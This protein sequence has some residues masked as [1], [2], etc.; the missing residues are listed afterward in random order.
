VKFPLA[1]PSIEP[2]RGYEQPASGGAGL[3]AY[4]L[5]TSSILLKDEH[6]AV[7][8]DG[9]VTRPSLLRVAFGRIAPD[10]ALIERAMRRLGVSS[11]DAVLCVHSH[12]D[13]A[14]DAPVWASLG[15]AEL[16]GS[17]STAQIGRGYGLPEPSLRVVSNGETVSYGDFRLTFLDSVH[18]PGDRFPGTVDA[19]LVPPARAAAW[20]TGA[21]YSVVV[22]HPAGTLVV[23]A[24]ANWRPGILHGRDAEVVYLGIGE[25]GRQRCAFIEEY[26]TQ[27]VRATSARRVVLVHWDDMFRGIGRPLRPMPYAMDD[28]P[29][30]FREILTRAETDGVEVVLPVPWQ[31]A[32]PFAGLG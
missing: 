20:K 8:C 1:H 14:L 17:P 28:F 9:F 3:T 19:P 23:H 24:S 25:L 27:V 10:R 22:T 31:P 2:Y 26:W 29:R 4:F 11:L 18:S 12:Y 30:T 6:T 7:L 5:G 16:L 21:A 32:D 13:H 15:G